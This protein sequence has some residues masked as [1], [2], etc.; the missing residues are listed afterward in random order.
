MIL[1]VA[2]GYFM[3]HGYAGTTMSGIA[4][5]LGGSKGTLWNHFPSKQELF[6]AVIDRVARA[7]RAQL[8][9]ILTHDD[10]LAMTLRRACISIIRK[11]TSPEAIALHRLIIA[12]GGRFPE[13]SRTFF[14]LAPRN[15]R[16]LI[17]KFLSGAMERGRLRTADPEETARILMALCMAGCHHQLLMGQTDHADERQ[18]EYDSGLAVDTFMRAYAADGPYPDQPC[19]SAPSSM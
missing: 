17:A 8:S 5:A 15:T 4:A 18:I 7:Y 19:R 13:L 6:A 1:T 2:Q 14:D 12:E 3:D 11:V 16:A 10:D 9:Q